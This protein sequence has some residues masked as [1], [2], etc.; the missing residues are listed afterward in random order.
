MT[1]LIRATPREVITATGRDLA[2]REPVL[3]GRCT[4]G[5][6]TFRGHGGIE[7]FTGN[8]VR[9]PMTCEDILATRARIE[10]DAIHPLVRL[11]RLVWRSAR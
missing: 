8:I 10:R 11:I 3:D 6:W 7:D 5:N 4:C 1:S 2:E 9:F